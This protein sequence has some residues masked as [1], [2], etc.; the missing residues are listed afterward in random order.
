MAG[1]GGRWVIA[2][3]ARRT[4]AVIE[5]RPPNKRLPPFDQAM[6]GDESH[7]HGDESLNAW[8][9]VERSI[10]RCARRAIPLRPSRTRLLTS[11]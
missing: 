3:V 1:G 8:A 9:H 6:L 5:L 10:E 7:I 11:T 2:E 4:L